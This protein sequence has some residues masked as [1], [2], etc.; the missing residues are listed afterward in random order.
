[1]QASVD[2]EA[3]FTACQFLRWSAHQIIGLLNSV[4]RSSDLFPGEFTIWVK[5][6]K[7]KGCQY[8][9]AEVKGEKEGW[10]AMLA[11]GC[12]LSDTALLLLDFS[13]NPCEIWMPLVVD[14]LVF[15]WLCFMSFLGLVLQVYWEARK[16]KV[17][18]LAL[19]HFFLLKL[20][21]QHLGNFLPPFIPAFLHIQKSMLGVM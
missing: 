1:M 8:T 19:S 4:L 12:I 10:E 11:L 15:K 9:V 5:V 18:F 3:A 7:A 21:L 2:I 16:F 14:I 6:A 13:Q 20:T 17:Y